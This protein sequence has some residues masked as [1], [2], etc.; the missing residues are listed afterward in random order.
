MLPCEV[1]IFLL[2]GDPDGMDP[3]TLTLLVWLQ[4]AA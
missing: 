2:L 1:P 3:P 4:V